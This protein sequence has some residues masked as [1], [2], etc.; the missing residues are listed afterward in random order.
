MSFRKFL[1]ADRA[2][3]RLFARVGSHVPLQVVVEG[4][5]LGADGAGEGFFSRVDAEMTLHVLGVLERLIAEGTGI[6]G[7]EEQKRGLA[8]VKR[9]DILLIDIIGNKKKNTNRDQNHTRREERGNWVVTY[10]W[11]PST[12][13][14]SYFGGCFEKPPWVACFFSSFSL[15]GLLLGREGPRDLDGAGLDALGPEP[16]GWP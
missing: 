1:G 2:L 13:R 9:R 11:P 14:W 6:P 3:V 8:L 12:L 10:D 5:T 16:V 15:V 4:E 7:K